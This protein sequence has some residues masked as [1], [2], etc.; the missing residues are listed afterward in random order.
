MKYYIPLLII[1]FVLFAWASSVQCQTVSDEIVKVEL[2]KK[3][4]KK[5][6]FFITPFY[7]FTQFQK[8]E[9]QSHTNNYDFVDGSSSYEFTEEQIQEHNDEFG[10]DYVN[11]MLGAKL[12]CR[13]KNGFGLGAYV[14]VNHFKFESWKSEDNSETH[15][16]D[17]PAL[18]FGLATNYEKTVWIDFS[19]LA[20]LSYNYCS[21]GSINV[22]NTSGEEVTSSSVK[23]MYWNTILALAY[24]HK[25]LTPFI[26]AGY[27]QQFVNSLTQEQYLDSDENGTEFYNKVEFDARFKGSSFYGI[28]GVDYQLNRNSVVYIS[29]SFV[30]PIRATV[31]FRITI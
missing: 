18:S 1:L 14:G 7:E 27:T 16:T 30:N 8:L 2:S 11:S 5:G 13:L 9:L 26:G 6:S 20:S 24:T 4:N 10:A 28:A 3:S 15:I 19:V 22:D 23:A 31:G 17:Y 21:T 29:S 25:K 12:Y